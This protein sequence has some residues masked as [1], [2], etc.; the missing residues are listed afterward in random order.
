[1]NVTGKPLG[2]GVLCLAVLA[3]VNCRG[4]LAGPGA[5]SGSTSAPAAGA[6]TR[7]ARMAAFY[8]FGPMEI[9]KLQWG[10][11]APTVT[12]VNGDRLN[13]L[14]FTN[15]RKARI[16]LLLQKRGFLPGQYVPLDI[17]DDDV[18][19][20]FGQEKAWRFKR[21][22]YDLDVAATSVVV[23]DLNGDSRPDLAFYAKD[24]LRV[25]LQ[26]EPAEA[27][28][29][30]QPSPAEPTWLS[31]RKLEMPGGLPG[32]NALAAGDLTG[33]GRNDL[34]LLAGDGTF[35]LSQ[36]DDGTLAQPVKYHTGG[37]RPRQLTIADV[38]GDGR[39]DLVVL[40]SDADFPV[41]VRYQ[42]QAGK[43]GAEL[44]YYLP[45]PR[46]LE[47]VAMVGSP[48]SL[49]LSLSR[50]S[51]RV[52]LSALTPEARRTGY[53]VL[54]YPL[55][56]TES[57]DKRDIVAADVDGDGLTDV[58]ASDPSRAEFLLFRAGAGTSLAAPKRFPGL[59]DMRRLAAGDLDGGGAWAVVALSVKEKII[60]ISR[61]VNGRL[62]FPVSV[63]ITGEPVAMGLADVNGDETLD[64]VYI[65]K[66]KKGAKYTLRTVLSVGRKAAAAGPELA[67]SK[68]TDKPLDLRL[69]DIDH[70]GRVDVMVVR[71]YGP[72]LLV[73]QAGPMEFSQV[74]SPDVHAGLVTNVQPAALSVA[75][76]GPGGTPAALLAKKNFARAVVFDADK[77]W[78]VVDQYP[79]VSEQSS[80]SAA[81][82]FRPPG[83]ADLAVVVYDSARG[84]LAILAREPDGTYRSEREVPV[85]TVSARKILHGNFGGPSPTSLLLCGARKLILVPVAGQ[86]HLLG[87]L[88]SF[89]P[90]VKGMQYGAA[91]V[92]DVNGDG[93]P[94][95]VLCDQ[96][97]H[98]M[99]I[100]AFDDAGSLVSA[101]KFKVF[102]DPG[103]AERRRYEN[104]RDSEAG[105]PA[106][107]RVGD[108]T[109]DGKNDLIVQVHDRIIVY[110]QE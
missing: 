60:A 73:R 98:H 30:G 43:L 31:A 21:V 64:L 40:G 33:D 8:G 58:V 76:L 12:D 95:V 107:V 39:M 83:Q 71:P 19:D 74:T 44:R 53:P 59:T 45:A 101:N 90:D 18:N 36:K 80:L 4:S 54:T 9:L 42:S 79:A 20:L 66:A 72:V 104:A 27:Q 94:E 16:D 25:A 28:P 77:G 26:G 103:A 57:A 5:S 97:R 109:G 24:A 13:D 68:L 89:A 52:R 10:I 56:A 3:A 99:H 35:V 6:E 96:G 87:K 63:S 85:G 47:T 62:T 75:P 88:A 82:A 15:N 108:V 70:D 86:T 105:Q 41:R 49:F 1:M 38:D 17:V 92:G 93:V 37:N 65:A 22:S 29:A 7:P 2:V 46:V 106:A 50:Q 55:P 14:V 32:P 69:A 48:R 51:G 110:P 61:F 91:A 100:L 23:A 34:A 78:R 11:G 81:G 67:L 102:E 84:K